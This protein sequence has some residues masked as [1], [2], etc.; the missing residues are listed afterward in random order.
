MIPDKSQYPTHRCPGG[1]IDWPRF[2]R[3]ADERSN[4]VRGNRRCL[5]NASY[6]THPK[7]Q[8]DL[9]FPKSGGDCPV[10]LF[11]HGGGFQEGDKY[12]YGFVS[13]GLSEL[14]II[15]AVISYRLA[16]EFHYPAAVRDTEAA[17]AWIHRE[18]KTLGGNPDQIFVGGHSAGGILTAE[19][20]FKKDWRSRLQLP[21]DVI[22][23]ALPLSAPFDVRGVDWILEYAPDLESQA[24]SSP[25][26]HLECFPLH[27]IVALGTAGQEAG[28]RPSNDALV[29]RLGSEQVGI[30]YLILEGMNHDDTVL[31]LAARESQLFTALTKMVLGS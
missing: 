26:Y 22:K 19:T 4:L 5:V 23:G 27:S 13:E 28:F 21:A 14:G 29:E 9:Y 31:S 25:L 10:F 24:A 8:L 16:P 3:Q 30:E 20:A 12:H 18:I 2:Y 6:G 17:I 15:T 7:Q 11:I 1:D